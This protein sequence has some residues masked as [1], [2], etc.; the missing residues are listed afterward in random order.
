[1]EILRY[2]QTHL[3]PFQ[4]SVF[5]LVVWLVLLAAIFVPAERL[6]AVRRQKV[7]RKSLWT[8]LAYFFLNSLLPAI[9]LGYPIYY[10][11]LAAHKFLP[12]HVHLAVA[13]MPVW[14]QLVAGF[15]AVQLGAYWA[16][17]WAHEIP[18]LW[19]FHAIH[20]SAE[21][22]DWLVNMRAH[23]LDMVFV[24]L[25][26]YVL[27]FLL[28]L[29]QP[30]GQ[31]N[32]LMPIVIALIGTFWGFFVHANVRWRFGPLEWLIATPA[33]HHWHHTHGEMTDRNYAATL[34]WLDRLF[35][36]YYMPKG[37]WPERYGTDTPV[38]PN[39]LGQLVDPLLPPNK[40]GAGRSGAVQTPAAP[41][42]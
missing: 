11:G 16:H 13:A 35:G 12:Y 42:S 32:V 18:L 39:L 31:A 28:G 20:H 40:N 19:R 38:S 27:L 8:D 3:S 41:I 26:G 1:M 6:L 7:M 15:L 21:E 33:F 10:L 4:L 37:R 9:I 36:T 34:P 30:T 5:R 23:P 14:L 29:A 22:I 17:R 2:L 24:R 25:C